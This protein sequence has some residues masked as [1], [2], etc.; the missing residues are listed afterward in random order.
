MCPY[1]RTIFI[2]LGGTGIQTI[3]LLKQK[4]L[5]SN[6]GE[7]PESI[8]FLAIDSDYNRNGTGLTHN[9]FVLIHSHQAYERYLAD[10]NSG[11]SY[12]IPE[13]NV[14]YLRYLHGS[15]CGMG[16]SNGRYIYELNKEH[17]SSRLAFLQD[18]LD[19]V[20]VGV[21]PTPNVDIHI[22]TSSCGGTGSGI[23]LELSKLV[24]QIIPNSRI[25]LYLYSDSF[26]THIPFSE[27]IQQ[28]ARA[29]ILEMKWKK[30]IFDFCTWVGPVVGQSAN[31]DICIISLQDAV[32]RLT[33]ILMHISAEP[34]FYSRFE[35]LR[36]EGRICNMISLGCHKLEKGTFFNK[37]HNVE[38]LIIQLIRCSSSMEEEMSI[39]RVSRA[40][41]EWYISCP[42]DVS[43]MFLQTT[44]NYV[45]TNFIYKI[46]SYDEVVMVY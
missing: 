31:T 5:A 36:N 7:L 35:T 30:N 6:N 39:E 37:M 10:T 28:N 27:R 43:Q 15:G 34:D 42:Q 17:I 11:V 13:C 32:N 18:E 21:I 40:I 2:G 16:R 41:E 12:N 3:D 19:H 22:I 24:R 1:I 45:G 26:Y 29:S 44:H 4:Y 8:R 9:E 23:F 33:E 38:A 20:Q 25:F 14:N 46:N